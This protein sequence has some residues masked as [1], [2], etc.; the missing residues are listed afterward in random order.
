MRD[1]AVVALEEVLAN[2]LPVGVHLPVDPVAELE[3]VHVEQL[4]DEGGHLPERL[5]E[6]RGIRVGVDE[7]ERAPRIHG[8]GRQ[9]QLVPV[10]AGLE[11]RTGRGLECAVQSVGPRVVGALQ[12]RAASVALGDGKAAVA[13]DVEKGAELALA[14]ARDDNRRQADGR[15]EERARLRQSA[16]VAGVGPG[17][18]E[19]PRL[20]P[21]KRLRIRVPAPRQRRQHRRG[22]SS[23]GRRPASRSSG[24]R[25]SCVRRR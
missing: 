2:D 15:G 19:D 11:V 21:S 7:D 20:L 18:A 12:R 25:R 6:R 13:A 5:G 9:A 14:R 22:K 16:E 10:E 23:S 8:P 24:R 3:R 4:G 17:G 1:R